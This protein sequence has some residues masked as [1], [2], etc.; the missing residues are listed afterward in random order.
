MLQNKEEY[1]FFGDYSSW[2][3]V[4]EE[5]SGYDTDVIFAKV[6]AALLKVKT[7][8]AVYEGETV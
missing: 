2:L 6:K 3:E 7:G 8:H 4:C 1:G 5:C